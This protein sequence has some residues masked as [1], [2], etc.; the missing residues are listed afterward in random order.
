MNFLGLSHLD[1][2]SIDDRKNC[3]VISVKTKNPMLTCPNCG[4][5]QFYSHDKTEQV[6]FDT[7][8]QGKPAILKMMRMRYKCRSCGKTFREP[9]PDIDDKRLMTSRLKEHIQK[10]A[11]RETF[12]VVARET[13][14]DEKTIRHVFDD[15]ANEKAQSMPF[16]TPRILGIDELKLVGSFRCILTNIEHNTVFD[17]LPSR[18]KEC[19]RE[20]LKKLP[21]KD[22]IEQVTM[23]MWRPYKDAVNAELPGRII[24]IDKFHIVRMA[25][26]SLEASR[27]AI[28][29]TLERKD[30]LKLKNERFVLL[31]RRHSLSEEET[32]KLQKWSAWYPEL[33]LAYDAKEAF[34]CLFDDQGLDSKTAKE[35]LIAWQRGIDPSIARHFE[36]LTKA[37]NNWMPE[38]LNGFDYPITNAYTESINRLAKDLQRM[39]RGYS[40]D[41]VR[42]KM[43]YDKRANEPTTS[44]IRKKKRVAK[45]EDS[46][47]AKWSLSGSFSQTNTSKIIIEKEVKY[48]GPHIPT[49]CELLEQGHFD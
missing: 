41:V 15:Y 46:T 22:N 28:R 1:A 33:G 43:L 32:E 10:R 48:Y 9:L 8:M 5:S 2:I 36:T 35:A 18:K 47:M 16:V 14:L 11:M 24:V 34:F 4:Y 13:G 25:N 26:E 7:P 20:Y 37:L 27:K 44:T 42:A 12:A 39:G 3:F 30:R 29:A 19:V 6:F 31:K 40:F 49:L 17:I 21:D 38:I 45:N 23:D